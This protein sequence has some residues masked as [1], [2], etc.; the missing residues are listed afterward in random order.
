[1]LL[2]LLLLLLLRIVWGV[3]CGCW[4]L[5]CALVGVCIAGIWG[6]MHPWTTTEARHV[7]ILVGHRDL[8]ANVWGRPMRARLSLIVERTVVAGFKAPSPS[9]LGRWVLLGGVVGAGVMLRIRRIVILCILAREPLGVLIMRH[10][11]FTKFEG[12]QSLSTLE[13][14]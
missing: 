1:M 11:G 5:R 14:A 8:P 4:R 13:G 6:L 12:R 9:Y 10:A 3:W 7:L 2:L